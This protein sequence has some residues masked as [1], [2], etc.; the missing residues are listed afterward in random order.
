MPMKSYQP[1]YGPAEYDLDFNFEL[2]FSVSDYLI[3]GVYFVF[4]LPVLTLLR[5]V[6]YLFHKARDISM[7]AHQEQEE[8][9][10]SHGLLSFVSKIF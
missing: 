4:I 9:V 5:L 7:P 2:D 6:Q 8:Q 1:D 3:I 10:R